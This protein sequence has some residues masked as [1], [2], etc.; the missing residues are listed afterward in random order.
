M[1][2]WVSRGNIRLNLKLK[3]MSKRDYKRLLA[4]NKVV[5]IPSKRRSGENGKDKTYYDILTVDGARGLI[6]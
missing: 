1:P 5:A 6:G 2:C 4:A 3:A